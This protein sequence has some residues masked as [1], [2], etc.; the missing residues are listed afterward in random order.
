MLRARKF[1]RFLVYKFFFLAEAAG[2]ASASK[3]DICT[4]STLL[5]EIKNCQPV[6]RAG[7]PI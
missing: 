7:N 5:P 1:Y 3:A 6:C 2:A 4:V